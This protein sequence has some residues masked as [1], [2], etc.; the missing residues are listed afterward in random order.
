LLLLWAALL[1]A[2]LLAA[3]GFERAAR[4]APHPLFEF[5]PLALAQFI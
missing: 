2:L 3:G 5:L 4:R 1:L